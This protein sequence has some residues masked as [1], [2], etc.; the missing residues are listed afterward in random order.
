MPFTFSPKPLTQFMDHQTRA[1]LG[2]D[3]RGL[4]GH[5]VARVGNVHELLH[6]Y[7]IEGEGHLHLTAI[8][9]T[10]ELA[11]TA[12][13]TDEVDALVLAQVS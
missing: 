3:P 5:D 1:E 4:G 13:A 6:R 2:L 8:D 11:E 12:D 10:L 7:G 9:T